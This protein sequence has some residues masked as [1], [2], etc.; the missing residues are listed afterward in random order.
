MSANSQGAIRGRERSAPRWVRHLIDRAELVARDGARLAKD[1]TRISASI[2]RGEVERAQGFVSFQLQRRPL[3]VAGVAAGASLI[4][5]AALAYGAKRSS[6]LDDPEEIV[7]RALCRDD[8]DTPTMRGPLWTGY[9]K[10]ARRVLSALRGAGLL[11]VSTPG[12]EV[13]NSHR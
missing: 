6:S 7:A 3:I 8:P 10:D 2:G 9:R 5:G 12:G 4:L 1:R 13:T 11:V